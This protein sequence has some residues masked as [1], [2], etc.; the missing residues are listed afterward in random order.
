[1]RKAFITFAA[2]PL[3]LLAGCTETAFLDGI[4]AGKYTPDET[5]VQPNKQLVMPPDINL[6]APA[7]ADQEVAAK[8]AGLE[9]APAAPAQAAPAAPSAPVDNTPVVPGTNMTFQQQQDQLYAKYNISKTKPDGTL[10]TPQELTS[11]LKAVQQQLRQKL[12]AK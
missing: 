2:L 4:G 9:P 3:L 10:K 7:N 5:A 6:P 8:T 11:E 1:M 12:T